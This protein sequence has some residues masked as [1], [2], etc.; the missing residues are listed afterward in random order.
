MNTKQPF[1]YRF[2]RFKPALFVEIYLPKKIRYQGALYECLRAGF[3]FAAV[4]THLQDS[5]HFMHIA[6]FLDD[7]EELY[8]IYNGGNIAQV[9]ERVNRM[10]QVFYGY[11]MYEVDGVFF[12]QDRFEKRDK[13]KE[14]IGKF[15]VEENVQVI[16]MMFMPNMKKT[17]AAVGVIRQNHEDFYTMRAF[18][19]NCLENQYA[20]GYNIKRQKKNLH[21]VVNQAARG[22]LEKKKQYTIRLASGSMRAYPV[23]TQAYNR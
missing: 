17:L 13:H 22:V 5:A 21:M 23:D 15:I 19:K 12:D 11:S 8:E 14:G 20:L 10:E 4:Q 6:E 16:R 3:D 2:N 9:S 7:Y 18:F 1:G